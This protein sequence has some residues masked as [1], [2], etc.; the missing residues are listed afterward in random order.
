MLEN[1]SIL[2]YACYNYG[3]RNNVSVAENQQERLV[4]FLEKFNQKKTRIFRDF[5]PK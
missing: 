5:T 2:H 1:L 4:N 3:M